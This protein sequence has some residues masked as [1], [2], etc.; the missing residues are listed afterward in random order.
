[1]ISL[2]VLISTVQRHV[3]SELPENLPLVL[4]GMVL[5]AETT[6]E[7]VEFSCDAIDSPP[8][9][10]TPAELREVSVTLQVFAR[11]SRQTIHVHQLAQTV[12][13]IVSGRLI[14]V[15]DRTVSDEPVIGGIRFREADVRDL[16]RIHAAQQRRPLRHVAVT[17]R[18]VVQAFVLPA[19]EP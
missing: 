3:A 6:P 7:W 4:P 18:A 13:A 9:R 8:Q 14:D 16:T 1:M 19:E 2:D 15:I 11:A 12:R 17:A 5:D 10:S